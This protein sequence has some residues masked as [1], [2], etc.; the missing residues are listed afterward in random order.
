MKLFSAALLA[1]VTLGS[2]LARAQDIGAPDDQIAEPSAAQP[3]SPAPMAAP[4]LPPAQIPAPPQQ[5]VE[6]AAPYQPETVIPQPTAPVVQQAPAQGQWVYT[7]QYGWVW[8]PYG[9]QY[10]YTPSQA[11]I[12]PSEYVYYPSYGWTWVTAPWVFG[13]GVS[14]YFGV[15]GA[16]HFG[17]YNRW[18]GGYGGYRPGYYGARV[19]SPGYRGYGYRS[20]SVYGGYRPG[21]VA[22]RATYGSPARAYGRAP[23]FAA[24]PT[25]QGRPGGFGGGHPGGFVGGHA[26]GAFHGFSSGH[27][28]GFGGHFGGGFHGGG[29]GFHGGFGGGHGGHR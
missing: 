12:Y 13:W 17:W 8:M 2:G 21:Y 16:S 25:F 29:G 24:H 23:A 1:T 11:G 20:A 6:E 15:Y 27:A 14:P 22:P 28:G 9:S 5:Q 3:S 7:Q 4:P 18:A 19:Y 10:T 26:G